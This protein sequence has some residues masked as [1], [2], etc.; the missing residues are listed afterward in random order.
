M[1][2]TI[3]RKPAASTT[4]SDKVKVASDGRTDDDLRGRLRQSGGDDVDP[5]MVRIHQNIYLPPVLQHVV[6]DARPRQTRRLSNLPHASISAASLVAF[7]PVDSSREPRSNL[8]AKTRLVLGPRRL[9]R[10]L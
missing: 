10:R 2:R 6:A 8:S 1:I 3:S 4:I 9:W 7:I 5:L